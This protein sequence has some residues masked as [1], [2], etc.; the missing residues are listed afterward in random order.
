MKEILP[1]VVA[2]IES[3]LNLHWSKSVQE[4]TTSVKT[5]LEEL[6]PGLYSKCLQQ[7]KLQEIQLQEKEMNRRLMWELLKTAI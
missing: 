4:V 7:L 5:M 3:N 6:Y 2:G 1:S